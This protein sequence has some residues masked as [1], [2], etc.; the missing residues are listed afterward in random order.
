MNEPDTFLGNQLVV[1]RL[2]AKLRAG[3]LPHALVFSGPE[4][5]GKRTYALRLVRALNCE[6]G[7]TRGCG[8]CP[9]CRKVGRGTH[10][11][12]GIVSVESGS[13]QIRIEQI[14]G[15]R[16]TLD[17]AP[18]EGRVR[19][20]I[21]DPAGRLTPGAANA[22]LKVLEEPPPGTVFFLITPNANELLVTIRSRCQIYH[23]A[24]LSLAAVRDLG[25]DDELVARWS[26]G[27][28]GWARQADAVELRRVR[29][30]MLGFLEAGF[31]SE[32]ADLA[33][34]VGTRLAPSREEHSEVMRAA[35]LLISDLLYLKLGLAGKLVNVDV[36]DRLAALSAGVGTGRLLEAARGVRFIEAN[37]KHNL[38][39]QLMTDALLVSLGS[40]R[41][42]A[43]PE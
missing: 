3:R 2:E 8:E 21:I 15:L 24:P 40:R 14:R 4:G 22:F 11:D 28:I 9:S 13:T 26:G 35:C 25:V 41:G 18:I 5:V 6:N 27:S 23:F 42:I 34:R 29:D 32:P 33:E 10:P 1:E 16:E 36:A 30:Q 31:A 43:E 19:A 20:W 37:L 39:S 7:G 17:L 12:L 38:N